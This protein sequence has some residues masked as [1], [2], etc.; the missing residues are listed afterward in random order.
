MVHQEV[1][2][3]HYAI[4]LCTLQN[5]N[6]RNNMNSGLYEIL[7]KIREKPGMYIGKPSVDPYF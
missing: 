6:F 5:K 3:V 4:A 1:S 2:M 7:G